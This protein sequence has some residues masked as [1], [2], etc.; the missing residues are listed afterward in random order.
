MTVGTCE[1]CGKPFTI[2]AKGRQKRFCSQSCRS[3]ENTKLRRLAQPPEY[4]LAPVDALPRHE[5]WLVDIICM[6]CGRQVAEVRLARE[7]D[8]IPLQPYCSVCGGQP[9]RGD[10]MHYIVDEKLPQELL[11]LERRI[12]RPPNWL[13]E[14]RAQQSV[15]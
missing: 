6:L 1:R 14:L 15:A 13:L 10:A 7:W 3:S 11:E 5:Y 2:S 12:G 8:R 4:V 9:I